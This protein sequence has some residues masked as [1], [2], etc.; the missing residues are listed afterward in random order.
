MNPQLEQEDTERGGIAIIFDSH[1]IDVQE[2]NVILPYNIEIV[3]GI[4]RT[5]SGNIR[6]IIRASFYY[7]PRARKK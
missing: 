4:G 7:P 2:L 3:W 1:V 6:T 5:K